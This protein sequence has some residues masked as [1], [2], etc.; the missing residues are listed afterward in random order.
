MRGLDATWQR[1]AAGLG[2]RGDECRQIAQR[3]Q[4]RAESVYR[5]EYVARVVARQ[6]R[7]LLSEPSSA[8]K[9]ASTLRRGIR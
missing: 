6:W 5:P 1:R 4:R 7:T 9:I 3:A 8:L 2:S